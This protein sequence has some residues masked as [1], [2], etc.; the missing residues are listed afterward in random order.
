[1]R[2]KTMF[3]QNISLTTKFYFI[4]LTAMISTGSQSM[5]QQYALKKTTLPACIAQID[6]AFEGTDTARFNK[7]VQLES[8]RKFY[9][10]VAGE[11]YQRVPGS[12]K[13]ISIFP[14]SAYVLMSGLLRY[15]NSGDETNLSANYS[16]I[17][18]FIKNGGSWRIVE[19]VPMDRS[20]K[21]KSQHISMSTLPEKGIMLTDTLVLDVNDPLGFS[22]RLNH[23]A[24]IKRLTLNGSPT[25]YLFSG[26][27]LWMKPNKKTVQRLMIDYVIDVEHDPNNKNSGYFSQAYG[28]LRNQYYWHPFFGFSS[29]NDRADFTIQCTI[30][31]AYH[32]ATSLPQ[33]ETESGELR[34]IT[35]K[36]EIATFGLSLYYDIDWQVSRTTKDQL[37]MVIYATPNFSPTTDVLVQQFSSD[38]DTLQKY[39]GRPIGSYLAIVQDRSST[40]GWKN[41]SNNMVV[42]GASGS[43]LIT[44]RPNPRAVFGHEIAHGWTSPSGPATNFLMEGWATYAES[45]LLSSVYGDSIIT[46]FFASQK[47]N[48]LDGK[49]DGN[50][51]LWEDYN[52]SGVSY[53]KGA[54][55]F[56]MLENQLG[57]E[58]LSSAMRSF[59]SSGRQSIDSFISEV[60]K[61]AGKDMAPFI[62]P[63]LKSR[64]IP[65]LSATRSAKGITVRQMGDVFI[66][67][68]EIIISLKNGTSVTTT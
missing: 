57:R 66:F 64:Q 4:L 13:V 24:K 20:N 6:S 36:S 1:M 28:H 26:G 54:W 9:A 65:E 55:L 7:Y 22:V 39:F 16:G 35:A 47:Q 50:R 18:K 62:L 25:S 31:K 45:L 23:L 42:A 41:R 21:I 40:S 52:N 61:S 27:L 53:S 29:P 60:S 67:N 8:L 30:P 11:R 37:E 14:D 19:K 38:I 46:R 34:R 12:S 43:T 17:Y 63:W 68:L 48:Y 49:F 51:S 56:Y 5:A 59:V 2:L 32:L 3:H 15:G 58:K 10:S 44:D 33:R